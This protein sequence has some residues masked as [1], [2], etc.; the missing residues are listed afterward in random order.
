MRA[1]ITSNQMTMAGNAARRLL[2]TAWADERRVD[3]TVI[4][5]IEAVAKTVSSDPV[6]SVTL[7]RTAIEPVHLRQYGYRELFWLAHRLKE[8]AP[9]DLEFVVDFYQAAYAWH[10]TSADTTQMGTSALLSLS[11]NKRQDYQGAWHQLEEFVPSLMELDIRAATQA[12]ARAVEGYVRRAHPTPSDANAELQVI[13]SINGTD[14]RLLRDSSLFWFRGGYVDRVDAPALMTGFAQELRKAVQEPDGESTFAAV[15]NTFRAETT[16]AGLWGIAFDIAAEHLHLA[17]LLAP[18]ASAEPI[19][20]SLDLLHSLGTYLTASF[21]ALSDA[22]RSAIE[23]AILALSGPGVETTRSRLA[24]CIPSGTIETTPMREYRLTLD[25]S[26]GA[27]P[28]E[29]VFKITSSY[30]SYDSDTHLA[31]QGVPLDAKET[32]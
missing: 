21:H 14:T 19:L 30:G 8:I 17:H 15:V 6:A 3:I 7:L 20:R 2:Q 4:T 29:P 13:F 22:N 9:H 31:S 10:E 5:G 16:A 1:A 25:Q 23:Q 12:V 28:N 24:G 26:G 11:S 32:V 27:P 18:L